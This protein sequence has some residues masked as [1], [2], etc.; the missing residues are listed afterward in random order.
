MVG[1]I[2]WPDGCVL[3]GLVDGIHGKVPS[4]NDVLK[5]GNEV[6]AM[7]TPKVRKK[8]FEIGTIVKTER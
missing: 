2:E 4:P 5:P 3:V 1:E 6:Y 7:V 8:F